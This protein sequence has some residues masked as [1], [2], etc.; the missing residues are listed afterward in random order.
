M[1]YGKRDREKGEEG[2][3]TR[4]KRVRGEEKNGES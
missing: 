3:M 4:R 1:R 2:G